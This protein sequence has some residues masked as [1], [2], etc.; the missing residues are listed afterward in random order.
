MTISFVTPI[1][2]ALLSWRCDE[3]GCDEQWHALNPGPMERVHGAPG[4]MKLAD[5]TVLC[6]RHKGGAK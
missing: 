2:Y 3:P 5:R 6:P 1:A 4:W